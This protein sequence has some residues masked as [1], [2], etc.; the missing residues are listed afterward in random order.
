[1]L[2]EKFHYSWEECLNL[3][4]I[5]SLRI[6]RHLNI[7]SL[8]KV[9]RERD[10]TLF[11]VFEFMGG[12]LLRLMRSRAKPFS[13]SEVRYWCFQ[14]FQDLHYM[15]G[16]GYFHRDLKPENLLVSRGLIKIGDTGSAKEINSSQPFTNYV[17]IRWYR[18]SEVILGLE[19]YSFKVDM[20][21]I[22]SYHGR[23][24]YV[25]TSVSWK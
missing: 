23:V 24:V 8:K 25:Q 21:A 5:N 14:V 18:A 15:H 12:N 7:M 1:M 13:E 9:I 22:G 11:F 6:L 10:N 2:K 20:W 17:T 16:K 4:E 19:D 3:E